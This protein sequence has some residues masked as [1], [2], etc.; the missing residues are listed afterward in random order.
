MPRAEQF[1]GP[2]Q[3]RVQAFT[4]VLARATSAHGR[5]SKH[6]SA[7]T[8]ALIDPEFATLDETLAETVRAAGAAICVAAIVVWMT[9]AALI[10]TSPAG[11]LRG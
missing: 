8:T 2:P 11:L 5:G 6:R 9:P 10:V 1:P 3:I 7:E 4:L